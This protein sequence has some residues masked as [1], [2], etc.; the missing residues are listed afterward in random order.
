[1]RRPPPPTRLHA[2]WRDDELEHKALLRYCHIE[3]I[4]FRGDFYVR[5]VLALVKEARALKAKL[6]PLLKPALP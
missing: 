5:E 2:T 4:L 3:A 6:R 1:M